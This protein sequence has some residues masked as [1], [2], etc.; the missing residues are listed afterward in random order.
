MRLHLLALV[1]T[2]CTLTL[3]AGAEQP[4]PDHAPDAA[5]LLKNARAT[6][7]RLQTTCVSYEVRITS[8]SWSDGIVHVLQAP[9]GRRRL[10]FRKSTLGFQTELARI[11]QR[12][13]VWYATEGQRHV[14]YRP[15]EVSFDYA[16][17]FLFYE[18]ANLRSFSDPSFA[19][20]A[21]PQSA[22]ANLVSFTLPAT[23]P[24]PLQHLEDSIRE[25]LKHNPTT[26]EL[27]QLSETRGL[28]D[29]SATVTFDASN[30][31]LAR[32]E[33][34]NFTLRISDLKWLDAVPEQEF[35]VSN[36]KWDDRTED[37]TTHDPDELV[38]F[39]HNGEWRPGRP[40]G[41]LDGRLLDLKTGHARRVPYRGAVSL[42]G[43]FAKDRKSVF[44]CGWST[45]A[46]GA[47]LYQIS[48][49]TGENRTLGDAAF[50]AGFTMA[51]VLSPDGT[52]L[53][54]IHNDF[55]QGLWGFRIYLIDIATGNAK[56]LG[57]RIDPASL[58]WERDGTGLILSRG[59]ATEA[60]ALPTQTVCR[61]SLDGTITPLF[62]G[63]HPL[64]LPGSD[65]ILFQ[66]IDGARLWFTC[67]AKGNHRQPVADG[68]ADYLFP[69]PSPDGKFLLFI[70]IKDHQAPAPT[71]FELGATEGIPVP[72]GPGLWSWPAWN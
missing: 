32:L 5:S 26:A 38:M 62:K 7:K 4:P 17:A 43:C 3:A 27:R 57:E 63:T 67:D 21:R 47:G 15:Y 56:P 42:P 71:L 28:L 39:A 64:R 34:P 9:D 23:D 58:S 19:A 25:R 40:D 36:T 65:K 18:L 49:S 2:T 30:G 59:N 53:A 10:I 20:A 22:A 16:P 12:D 45:N 1:V 48:L 50:A 8:A 13:N 33:R 55:N 46:T 61:M 31:L 52:T 44:V 69:T 68:L 66:E 29:N 72:V 11:V 54:C 51:P 35:A 60:N 70:H 24:Q 41:Y 6:T 14:K 37:P